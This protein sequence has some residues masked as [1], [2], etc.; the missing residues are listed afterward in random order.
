MSFSFTFSVETD[1]ILIPKGGECML[2]IVCPQ[3][4]RYL[5][6]KEDACP[7]CQLSIVDIK[8]IEK[9]VLET[10][11]EFRGKSFGFSN[12]REVNEICART[13]M[14]VEIARKF[15]QNMEHPKDFV[16]V[17]RDFQGN[18]VTEGSGQ[19][20]ETYRKGGFFT[21]IKCPKCRSIEFEIID[22]KKKFSFGKALVGNTVGGLLGPAGAIAGTFQGVNGKNGKTKFI[23]AHC[24]YVWEQKI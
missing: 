1:I 20:K 7:T 21:K 14:S 2:L 13:G 24:G 16:Y 6:R 23:C 15:L 3:C 10:H 5:D 22:T 8:R 11:N 19:P 12:K 9:I 17:K 18:P 4:G